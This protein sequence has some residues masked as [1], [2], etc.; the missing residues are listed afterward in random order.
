MAR[1]GFFEY[2]EAAMDALL[3]PGERALKSAVSDALARAAKLASPGNGAGE[4][5]PATLSD[6]LGRP[7]SGPLSPLEAAVVLDELARL[8]PAEGFA[9]AER[10]TGPERD[11]GLAAAFLGASTAILETCCA[12]A[13]A[14]GAFDVII[15]GARDLQA[16][17]E[18]ARLDIASLRLL[19]GREAI[20]AGVARDPE[21]WSRL[22]RQA[23]AVGEAVASLAE[24][25]VPPPSPA[26]RE[27]SATLR[28]AARRIVSSR[29]LP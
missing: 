16:D 15:L 26:V 14:S 6:L 18:E 24:R 1:S 3:S 7:R 17:W 13:R 5:R 21:G 10:E 9:F 22:L 25:A 12:S 8:R 20:R 2:D 23:A 19:A 29:S 11:L 27:A 4:P 28:E